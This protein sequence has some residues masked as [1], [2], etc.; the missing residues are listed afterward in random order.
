MEKVE[1]FAFGVSDNSL[2]MRD[3]RDLKNVSK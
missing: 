1:S 2:E 3:L